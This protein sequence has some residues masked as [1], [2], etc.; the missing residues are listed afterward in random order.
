MVTAHFA[1]FACEVRRNF[2]A[3]YYLETS[4]G[5]DVKR[6]KNM[7]ELVL[8][9]LALGVGLAMDACAVSMA[10]GLNEPK[11]SLG[12]HTL[13]AGMFGFFQALMPMAGWLCVNTLVE[14][15]GVIKPIIPYVSLALLLYV[16][17]KM[18]VDGIRKKD[19]DEE[20]NKLTFVTLLIQAIATSIDALS[21]GFAMTEFVD[22][23]W[24]ALLCSGIIAAV[25]FVISFVAVILGRKFGDKLGDKAQ[26]LGGIVL[27]AIGIEIFVK[28]VFF[29]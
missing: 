19:E 4:Y 7:W 20:T 6:R 1:I 16:G 21:T 5:S 2:A 28:G 25:T 23:V 8:T 22:G 14:H 18:L 24:Q 15:F 10:N 12:K 11:M 13:I 9:S 3:T 27:I 29:A 17:I 26:I